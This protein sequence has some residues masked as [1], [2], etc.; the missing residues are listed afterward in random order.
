[1]KPSP[2]HLASNSLVLLALIPPSNTPL[3]HTPIAPCS[4]PADV[5]FV[6]VVSP[7]AVVSAVVVAV[8]FSAKT[9]NLTAVL[10]DTTA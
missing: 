3:T 5:V 8:F 7:V 6:A 10:E 9:K 2:L 1:M 4:R